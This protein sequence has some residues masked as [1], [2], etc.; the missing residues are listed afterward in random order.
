M[1]IELGRKYNH[2]TFGIVK[3]T[4][5]VLR[6]KLSPDP[7]NALKVFGVIGKVIGFIIKKIVAFPIHLIAFAITGLFYSKGKDRPYKGSFIYTGVFIGLMGV[8]GVII[9]VAIDLI[10]A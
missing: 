3:K 9:K 1:I 5:S 4:N 2:K 6:D 7:T 10:Q 8:V